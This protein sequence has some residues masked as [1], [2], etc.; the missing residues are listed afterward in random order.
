VSLPDPKAVATIRSVVTPALTARALADSD[1]EQLPLMFATPFMIA[2]MER[3]CA[4]LLAPLLKPGELSVGARIEV[5]HLAP[6]AIGSAVLCSARFVE[7]QGPLYWFE[8]WAEDERRRI[9][10]GR[11]ARA[12]VAETELTARAG[13]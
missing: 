3:A 6:T 11:V 8:V 7:A 4:Q 5:A 13:A 1:A 10:K 12:I 9:G 2:L